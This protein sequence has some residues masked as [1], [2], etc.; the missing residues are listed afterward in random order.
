MRKH[1]VEGMNMKESK[2]AKTQASFRLPG[3]FHPKKVIL[4]LIFFFLP[5]P[6]LFRG[7]SVVILPLPFVI[8]G[9]VWKTIW[10]L[11]LEP[12]LALCKE[13]ALHAVLLLGTPNKV[14][15]RTKKKKM[16]FGL[17]KILLEL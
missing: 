4:I 3:E 16:R 8:V 5:H 11:G 17:F 14:I 9:S 15:L 1:E 6:A 2:Q 10:I 12:G 7:Y 13:N